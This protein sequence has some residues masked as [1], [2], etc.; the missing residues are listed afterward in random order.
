[1]VKKILISLLMKL[2]TEK[3]IKEFIVLALEKLVNLT[4]TDFDNKILESVKSAWDM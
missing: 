4:K 1:M 2:V 3:A